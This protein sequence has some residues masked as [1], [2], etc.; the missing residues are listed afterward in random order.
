MQNKWRNR[1]FG[2]QQKMRIPIG[3]YFDKGL[4]PCSWQESK[5][6]TFLW[7]VSD[8]KIAIRKR[9]KFRGAIFCA[10]HH[11]AAIK[12][13]TTVWPKRNPL[14][15][16]QGVPL[17]V[18]YS[19]TCTVWALGGAKGLS[20]FFSFRRSRISVRSFS[21]ALGPAG[22]SGSGCFLNLLMPFTIKK[23]QNA[24]IRKSITF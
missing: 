21:S 20:Y 4:S 22:A 14:A 7:H 9:I 1:R 17:R 10:R 19:V 8:S 24:T 2:A 11:D 5:E 12:I 16:W 6:G 23:M 3:N 18:G 13:E 15:A